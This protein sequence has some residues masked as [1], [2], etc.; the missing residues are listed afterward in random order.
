MAIAFETQR[1][2]LIDACLQLADQGYLAGTGGNLALRLD[3]AHFAVTPSAADY[4]QLR[5]Q[6]IAVLRLD[7]LAQV[8]GEMAPSVE[9]G[10]HAAL[11]RARPSFRASVH[12]HQPLASAV[13]LLNRSLPLSEP[14]DVADLGPCVQIV[15]Y[16]PSGTA[17][18]VSTLRRALRN[19]CHAYLL[20]NHG[21][22]CTAADLAAAVPLMGRIE[23]A[24]AAHLRQE[25]SRL[26]MGH[27]LR[28]L[29][30]EACGATHFQ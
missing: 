26:P 19:D 3:E 13:A 6:D 1:G 22:V 2:A 7:T 28:E 27:P 30:L 14:A 15:G 5:P 16:A 4:Y 9:R 24:A 10:L 21:L 20:R 11:L 29:A 12:T 17:M 23:A 25:A 8:Q 18:L